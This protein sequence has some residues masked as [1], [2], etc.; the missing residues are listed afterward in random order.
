MLEVRNPDKFLSHISRTHSVVRREILSLLPP[1]N[2]GQPPFPPDNPQKDRLVSCRII[3]GPLSSRLPTP[4][5]LHAPALSDDEWGAG[6]LEGKTMVGVSRN[7]RVLVCTD[8]ERA[9]RSESDFV[10]VTSMIECEPGNS[11]DF[12][13]GGWLSI[14][15]TPAGK[16]IICEIKN[17]IYI[18][19]LGV[20]GELTTE[21]PVLVATTSLPA[22][23]VP[24]SFMGV[25][26]DCIMST[27]T[28]VGPEM[29]DSHGPDDAT[30]DTPTWRITPTKIIRVLSL[31]P[32]L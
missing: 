23:G 17:R 18:L 28:I 3:T 21:L 26:D 19:P 31:A 14:H 5:V 10:A 25:Y 12:D 4:V 16:R 29:E 6:M 22:L 8:W 7:G 2:R 30:E 13:L 11:T 32:E 15:E 27:F 20:D 1:V 24:V 9:L